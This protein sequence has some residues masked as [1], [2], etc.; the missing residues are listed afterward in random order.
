MVKLALEEAAAGVREQGHEPVSACV[1][2]DEIDR[3]RWAHEQGQGE[4]PSFTIDTARRIRAIRPV[5][6]TMR[7]IIG[8]DQALT[9][10]MWREWKELFDIACPLVL[11]RDG[12]RTKDEFVRAMMATGAWRDDA[13]PWWRGTFDEGL[14]LVPVSSTQIREALKRGE[15]TPDLDPSVRAYIDQHALYR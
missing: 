10:H 7:L 12:V 3:A 11:P 14:P 15:P 2:T 1:W 8:V 13:M 5:G 6:V 9:F 4:V